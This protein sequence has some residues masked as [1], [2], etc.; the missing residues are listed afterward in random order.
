MK[1][2]IIVIILLILLI[3]MLGLIGIVLILSNSEEAKIEEQL[4]DEGGPS[5]GY[6]V[7]EVDEITK[8][9][10]KTILNM[11]LEMVNIERKSILLCKR[12]I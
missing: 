7:E 12:N 5:Q 2:K 3:I 1:K 6:D 9:T 4:Y 11:L 10:S 8:E